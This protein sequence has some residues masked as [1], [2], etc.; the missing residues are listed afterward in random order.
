MMLL[1]LSASLINVGCFLTTTS[2]FSLFAAQITS[3]DS[4]STAI[5]KTVTSK[6]TPPFNSLF[7][8]FCTVFG[9]G[10]EERK[11]EG[12]AR[13]RERERESSAKA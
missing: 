6:C 13:E 4:T 5:V 8:F 11:V 3:S 10:V 12:R 7:L 1:Q 2:M 9:E